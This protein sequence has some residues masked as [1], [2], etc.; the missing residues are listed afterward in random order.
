MFVGAGIVLALFAAL[1]CFHATAWWAIVIWILAAWQ[2]WD[3]L[4]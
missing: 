2:L 3:W 1:G 4:A